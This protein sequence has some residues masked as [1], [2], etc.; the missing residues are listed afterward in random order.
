MSRITL[1]HNPKCSKSRAARALLEE[2]G[3]DFDTIEYLKTPPSRPDLERIVSLIDDAPEKLVRKDKNWA[4][5][6]LDADA[7]TEADAVVSVLLDHPVQME[8]PVVL[9]D[10]RGLIA[11]PPERV[12]ELLD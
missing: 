6:G 9:R 7:C 11:R 5:L 3:A 8:R 4:T 10:D 12:L 2:H 1:Y